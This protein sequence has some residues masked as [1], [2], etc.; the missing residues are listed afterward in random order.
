R[1]GGAT[2]SPPT[3]TTGATAQA[4]LSPFPANTRW[5]NTVTASAGMLTG[6]PVTFSATG[7]AGPATQAAIVSG[8]AQSATVSTALPAPLVV[9]V[10]DANN[11]P[12]AG[13]TVTFAVAS[14]GGTLSAASA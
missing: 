14:S 11:N 6:S 9:G 2:L 7:T 8:S 4:P 13:F 5:S 3:V 1:S 10:K 12:L